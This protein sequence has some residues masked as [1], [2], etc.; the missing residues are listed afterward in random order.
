M[1]IFKVSFLPVLVRKDN[2]EP[3]IGGRWMTYVTAPNPFRVEDVLRHFLP[4]LYAE[5]FSVE[6]VIEVEPGNRAWSV[7]VGPQGRSYSL[8]ISAPSEEYA[9]KSLA[10]AVENMPILKRYVDIRLF[11]SRPIDLDR[12]GVW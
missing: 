7:S 3:T 1:K 2:G 12:E 11:T 4:E 5:G 9:E 10:A 8:L 6:D